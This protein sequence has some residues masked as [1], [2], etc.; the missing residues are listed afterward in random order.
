MGITPTTKAQIS[1]HK[2]LTRRLEH[3]L[4]L[5]DI[6]MIHDPLA[7]RNRAHIFSLAATVLIC[8]GALAMAVFKPAID[9]GDAAIIQAESGQLYV[10]IDNQL[11][12]VAN[13][14]SARLIVGEA[15]DIHTGS[16]TIL[17]SLPK[18]VPIGI[19]DAPGL[20]APPATAT[21]K[22]V[23]HA[24]HTTTRPANRLD[25]ASNQITVIMQ[26]T[27]ANATTTNQTTPIFQQLATGH[28][29]VALVDQAEWLV[30]ANGRGILP[31]A[32]TPDGRNIRHRLGITPT[33]PRWS[34]PPQIFSAIAE[35]PPATIPTGILEVLRIP[36]VDNPQF[37]ARTA[38]GVVRLAPIQ[39]DI[40]VDSGVRM[41]NGTAT[42]LGANPDSK[43]LS[44]F[45]LPDRVPTWVDPTAQ[46]LCVGEHGEVETAPLI[47]GKPPWGEAVALA[48]KAVATHFVG[49]GWAVGVDTGS[50]I[51]VVS[52]HGL[53]HQVEN[54]ETAAALGISHFYSINWDMLRLLPSGTTLSKQ[55]ALQPL[56]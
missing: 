5:G 54:R 27:G 28:A 48:G 34:P 9:P 13:L 39:A 45:P 14:A 2:F 32:D 10:R 47:E 1:G 52:A 43:T 12:P 46:P 50:G 49:P 23:P 35:K 38:D 24:C 11:H 26:E 51:H 4:V 53:R 6:R 15:A 20:I 18:A 7:T 56:Y 21:Q 40:L 25:M 22:L 37:W 41:Q 17:K 8:L 3:G 29:L 55:Q 30:T 33:T 42:E 16:D 31:P 19:V 36:G 44:S